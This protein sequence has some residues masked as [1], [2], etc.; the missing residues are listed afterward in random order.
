MKAIQP[1]K[2]LNPASAR[3]SNAAPELDDLL[4]N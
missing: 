4:W 1:N 3:T 2:D